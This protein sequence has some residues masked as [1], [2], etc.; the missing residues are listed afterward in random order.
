M[1]RKWALGAL[2]GVLLAGV[3]TALGAGPPGDELAKAK[4][5]ARHSG[6]GSGGG[7]GDVPRT[8]NFRVLGH[9]DL[10][11]SESNGDVW[12]HGN[13]AYVGTWRDPC[14]GRGVKIVD[15]S[16]V[17]SPQLIGTL[18]ARAGT[19]AE[20]MV[21]RRVSTPFFSGDLMGVGIQRCG[22]DPALDTQEFGLQLWNVTN[23]YAPV[24]ITEFGVGHGDGGVHELDL[25]Q[26]GGRVYALLAHPFSEWF[27]PAG[28]GDF[29]IVDVTNP[30]LPVMTASW[31]AGMNGFSRGPYWGQGD[32]GSMFGHSARAS[33]DGRKAYVSYW[34]LG[35]LTFDITDVS[36][37]VLLT[38]TTYEEWEDG[39]AHS[40]T[41]YRTD[42]GR[43]LILQNDEDF[44]AKTP[45][46]IHYG[47]RRSGLANE[48]FASPPIWLERKHRI[49]GRVVEAANQGCDVSDYPAGTAG[50]IAVVYTPFPFFDA[51]GDEPQCLQQEQ[52]AAAAAAGAMAVVHDFVAENTSPQWF[53]FAEIDIFVLFTDHETAQ[54]MVEAGHATIKAREPAWGYLRVYDARTGRQIADFD[55]APNVRALPVPEGEWSIHNTEVKGDRAYS[56]W[57]SNGI[58]ALDLGPLDRK[59][60]R[61]PK[62]V[63]QFVPTGESSWP[64]P[65]VWGVAIRSDGLIFASDMGSGLW[66]VKPKGNAKP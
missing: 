17:S 26:R 11:L 5:D 9:H 8:K 40:M 29:M 34:D 48:G 7:S 62:M 54:G 42:R 19:S 30:S 20:D 12:V 41:P 4:L 13:F 60:P 25:F 38:R 44:S 23:P 59:R 32:F 22:E 24:F 28:H 58:V 10:G 21:V 2:C 18:A 39:D 46:Q 47:N 15:V 1:L 51:S 52:E 50:K 53:D 27:D 3:P 36:N 31:G 61:D 43:K 6:G 65:S 35:V 16:D 33:A 63:G 57:Y 37:P 66:I 55:D 56:S 45:A 64:Y 14:N 49:S